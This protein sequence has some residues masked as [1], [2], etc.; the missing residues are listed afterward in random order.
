MTLAK[1][2]VGPG[3]P[4]DPGKYFIIFPTAMGSPGSSSPSASGM[5][6]TFPAYT[7]SDMVNAQYR[8]IT[9]KYAIKKLADIL[10]PE[11]L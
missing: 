7:V 9:E 6:A 1:D 10:P 2:M 5:G 4:L 11:L 3:K 8:L